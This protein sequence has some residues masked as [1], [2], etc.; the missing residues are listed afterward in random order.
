M[1]WCLVKHTDNFTFTFTLARKE[2]GGGTDVMKT[3]Q[4]IFFDGMNYI[5]IIKDKGEVSCA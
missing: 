2:E 3:S 1:A 5:N 4:T